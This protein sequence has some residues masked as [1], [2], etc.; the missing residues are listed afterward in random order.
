MYNK[1]FQKLDSNSQFRDVRHMD[2]IRLFQHFRVMFLIN[3]MQCPRFNIILLLI[4]NVTL[5][6]LL[7]RL[8][9]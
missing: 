5:S 4:I 6:T 1:L 9:I 7:Q 2:F 8:K 3:S